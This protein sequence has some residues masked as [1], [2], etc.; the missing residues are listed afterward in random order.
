MIVRTGETI[1]ETI[2]VEENRAIYARLVNELYEV[3]CEATGNVSNIDKTDPSAIINLNSQKTDNASS[4]TATIEQ[5]D[6]QSGIEIQSCKWVY[7]TISED[8]GTNEDAYEGGFFTKTPEVLTLKA[9]MQGTYYLHILSIDKA[10]NKKEIKSKEVIVEKAPTTDE[11]KTGD[12]INYKDNNGNTIRCA[13]LYDTNS[14]FGKDGIQIV[15][16]NVLE[17]VTIGD[18]RMGCYNKCI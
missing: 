1:G 5:S 2:L 9:P 12:Y 6:S 11:L 13:V 17:N 14:N 7:N 10:G 3:V 15:A 8:I 4:I 18:D 16:M